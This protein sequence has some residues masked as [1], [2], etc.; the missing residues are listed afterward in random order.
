[1]R[2][3]NPDH[4]KYSN[5]IIEMS[6]INEELNESFYIHHNG[7]ETAQEVFK[8]NA[9]IISNISDPDVDT[10][11]YIL[12]QRDGGDLKSEEPQTPSEDTRKWKVDIDIKTGWVGVKKCG[13]NKTSDEGETYECGH[14][15]NNI[16][17]W[18]TVS[19]IES[20]HANTKEQIEHSNIPKR[21]TTTQTPVTTETDYPGV[22]SS[23]KLKYDDLRLARQIAVDGVIAAL[24]YMD[25]TELER[26]YNKRF[27]GG[28]FSG[29]TRVNE[30]EIPHKLVLEAGKVSNQP[31]GIIFS[32]IYDNWHIIEDRTGISNLQEWLASPSNSKLSFPDGFKIPFE[33]ML[34]CAEE[35]DNGHKWKVGKLMKSVVEENNLP[36]SC[37]LTEEVV[38]LGYMGSKHNCLKGIPWDA[39]GEMTV[40]ETA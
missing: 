4:I 17:I 11:G 10:I 40:G 27:I 25:K 30:I 7:H 38:D 9:T 33:H 39:T 34:T 26:T 29:G 21:S 20:D 32:V 2:P 19:E 6:I 18:K 8:R 15:P 13:I 35:S 24:Y 16:K 5:M 23:E 12:D 28:K 37:K 31:R 3:K 22:K 36:K 1:M 14:S